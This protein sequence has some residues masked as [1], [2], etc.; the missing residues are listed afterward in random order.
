[1]AT[2]TGG[3]LAAVDAVMGGRAVPRILCILKGSSI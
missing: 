2:T 3:V 1:M